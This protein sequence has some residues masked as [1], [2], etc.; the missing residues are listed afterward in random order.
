[1]RTFHLEPTEDAKADHHRLLH[2]MVGT[3]RYRMRYPTTADTKDDMIYMQKLFPEV[4]VHRNALSAMRLWTAT[5]EYVQDGTTLTPPPRY[6]ALQRKG[7]TNPP[8]PGMPQLGMPPTPLP[9]LAEPPISDAIQ[10]NYFDDP[11]FVW[12]SPAVDAP[13][14]YAFPDSADI[15]AATAPVWEHDFYP[16]EEQDAQSAEC[17]RPQYQPMEAHRYSEYVLPQELQPKSEPPSEGGADTNNKYDYPVYWESFLSMIGGVTLITLTM[18][19]L[20]YLCAIGTGRYLSFHAVLKLKMQ[21]EMND[22]YIEL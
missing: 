16:P 20:V 7:F 1:M 15:P 3:S 2:W 14:P 11:S 8:S 19:L 17:M 12:D 22:Y 13:Q 6:Q 4:T 21:D 18:L 10:R 9:D 5:R